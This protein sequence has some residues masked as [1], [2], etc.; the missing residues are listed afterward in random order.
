MIVVFVFISEVFV[1]FIIVGVDFMV[2]L[3]VFFCMVIVIVFIGGRLVMILVV[4][5]VMFLLMINLV[6]DYGIEYL[7]VVIVLIGII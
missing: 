6:K 7:F 5:G 3:Y 2:G 1:F 4:I